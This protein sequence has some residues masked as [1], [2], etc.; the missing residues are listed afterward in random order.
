MANKRLC[1]MCHAALRKDGNFFCL[2]KNWT[3]GPLKPMQKQL[4]PDPARA[5]RATFSGNARCD[6]PAI[7]ALIRNL[8]PRGNMT[9]APPSFE[10]FKRVGM[11]KRKKAVGPDGVLLH[12]VG[13]M[14]N[15][16]VHN[17]YEG[18]LKVWRTRDIPQHWLWSE[19]VSMY[20]KGDF[21]RLEDYQPSA[22]TNSI[23]RVV[24]KLYRPHLQR[25]VDQVASPKQYG[26]RPLHTATEQAATLVN[27]LYEHEKEG[28]APFVV[29]LHVAKGFPSTIDEVIFSIL[30]HVGLPPKYVATFCKIYAHTN[31]KADIQGVHVYF[32][33]M[34]GDKK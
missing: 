20:K 7:E 11:D 33:P 32:K 5:L 23:H 4:K 21:G 30:N 26:S 6:T 8:S 28:Q 34:R 3:C 29:L 9:D 31:T 22:V 15:D 27:S 24:M 1:T 17:L 13:M 18:L 14:P 10:E 12:F 2:T 19:V 16:T 25:L